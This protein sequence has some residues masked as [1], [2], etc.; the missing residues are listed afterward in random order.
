MSVT[1]E[2]DKQNVLH[3]ASEVLSSWQ[4]EAHKFQVSLHYSQKKNKKI[5]KKANLVTKEQTLHDSTYMKYFRI[6]KF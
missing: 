1:D 4:E 5:N 2:K 3:T 6:V